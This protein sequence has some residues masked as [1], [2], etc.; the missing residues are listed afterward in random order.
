MHPPSA[1][2][3]LGEVSYQ[4]SKYLCYVGL[5]IRHVNK[6]IKHTAARY[7][8]LGATELHTSKEGNSNANKGCEDNKQGADEDTAE[9]LVA[10]AL[11]HTQALCHVKDGH[12]VHL[13]AG[14]S[15][16][17]SEVRQMRVKTSNNK[18]P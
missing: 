3:I 2:D 4:C 15:T 8:K 10:D 1:H 9:E 13:H 6:R 12:G 17:K 7:K 11:L 14:H 16:L 18:T 5:L